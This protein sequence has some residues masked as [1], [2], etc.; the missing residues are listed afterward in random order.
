MDNEKVTLKLKLYTLDRIRGKYHRNCEVMLRDLEIGLNAL[1]KGCPKV[2]EERIEQC[3]DTIKAL[4][5]E[6]PE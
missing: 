2:T 3:I 6:D 5:Q 4:L 1:L